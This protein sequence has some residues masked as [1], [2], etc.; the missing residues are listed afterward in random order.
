M[1]PDVQEV[2]RIQNLLGE[3]PVW[4]GF[5]SALYW[6]DI[7]RHWVCRYF[8]QTGIFEKFDLGLAV[9]CFAFR[10]QG[11]MILA[12]QDGISFWDTD[13]QELDY[14]V[15]ID[16]GG[17]DSRFNDGKVDP[18]GR[19]WAGMMGSQPVH[20]LYRLDPDYSLRTMESNIQISNGIGWSP[21]YRKMYYTDTP[22][23]KID[24]YDF[25]ALTGSI[26]NRRLFAEIP[27]SKGVPDGLAVDAEGF[28]WSACWG[29]WRVIRYDPDGKTEKE[30]SLPAEYPTSCAFGGDT[31]DELYITSASEPLTPEEKNKRPMDGSLF[32]CDAGVRGMPGTCFAG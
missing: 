21:D 1:M 27:A 20:N 6:V 9:G 23:G 5:E 8:H 11:G 17:S 32:R 19:F 30:L 26:E 22:T 4:N 29:G 16:A 14:L 13:K 15:K 10:E 28:V 25:D 31:L 7:T 18:Q 2:L 24:Q 12:V 3:G